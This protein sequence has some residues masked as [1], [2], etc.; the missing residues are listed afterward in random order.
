MNG[1]KGR[2]Y[3]HICPV[4]FLPPAGKKGRGWRTPTAAWAG[5]LG[6]EGGSGVREK[7]ERGERTRSP[8]V[9]WAGVVRGG[10]ATRA[11]AVSGG[12]Y[13]GA[14][15]ELD[16]S[17]GEGGNGEESEG[18]LLRPSPW[19]EVERGGGSAVACGGGSGARHGGTAELGRRGRAEA[20]VAVVVEKRRG[21]PYRTNKAV[22]RWNA[23][24]A[25]GEQRGCL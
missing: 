9:A 22:G 23:A 10:P 7:R 25:A 18:N 24:V 11:A 14:A 20:G 15:A 12:S 5:G 2:G 3:G 17:Q 1:N 13:G 16:G 4:F 8:A 21:G 6:R 19:A